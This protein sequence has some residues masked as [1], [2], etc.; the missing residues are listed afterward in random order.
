MSKIVK[1]VKKPMNA[2][3]VYRKQMRQ[4]ITQIYQLTKS[5]D[6]SRIAG[7]SWAL[8]PEHVKR[9]FYHLALL[10]QIQKE[11]EIQ[12]MS[13]QSTIPIIY[14]PIS[15]TSIDGISILPMNDYCVIPDISSQSVSED[16]QLACSSVD[17]EFGYPSPISDCQQSF[18]GFSTE[19]AYV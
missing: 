11:Q 14:S 4:K 9:H 1:K 19:F 17:F 6:I 13:I 8:E 18:D 10:E 15:Q 5:Q 16:I 12:M 2:F 3:F 7:Q